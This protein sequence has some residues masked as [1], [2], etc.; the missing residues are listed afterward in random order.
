MEIVGY[1]NTA[2]IE[3]L[4]RELIDISYSSSV[5][6][7]ITSMRKIRDTVV[8]VGC[9]FPQK[10]NMNIRHKLLAKGWRESYR[11]RRNGCVYIHMVYD[12]E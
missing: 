4:E 10:G 8:S 3:K 6:L 11:R 2:E 1:T 9:V 7:R 12:M 5:V